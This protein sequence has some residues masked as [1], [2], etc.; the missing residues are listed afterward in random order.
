MRHNTIQD[1]LLRLVIQE[2]GCFTWPGA[3]L[4]TGYGMVMMSGQKRYVHRLV[5]EHFHG[6]I[7]VGFMIDHICENTSCANHCHL[8][9]VSP[10][11][12]IRRKGLRSGC[13]RR[14]HIRNAENAVLYRNTVRC[15]A[16]ERERY[17]NRI[18]RMNAA[19]LDCD[20]RNPITYQV[21]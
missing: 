13:C 20:I 9:A 6:D 14:G 3:K 11:E 17:I 18:A 7:P 10:S 12:N 8:D 19:L 2:N 15:R 21:E 16:C 5:F 1:V 4:P